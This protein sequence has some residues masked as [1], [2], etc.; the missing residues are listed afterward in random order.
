MPIVTDFGPDVQVYVTQFAIQIFP[1]PAVCPHCQACDTLIGHGFY[2][3]HAT[4]GEHACR[5]WIKRWYCT[6]CQHTTSLLPS[7][8]LRFRHYLLS[9]I[10]AVVVA[11][12]AAHASLSQVCASAATATG[13]PAVITSRDHTC[14]RWCQS[15]KQQAARWWAALQ[16]TLAQHDPHSPGLDP[17][18]EAAGPR[19][20]PAALLHASINLLAWAQ[21]RWAA[22]RSY[23]LSE[24]LRFLWHWGHGQGLGR[25]V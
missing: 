19:D 15:F 9:V 16:Q 12:F 20:A 11:R 2:A 5:L 23:G 14:V 7:F 18:G 8:L 24:R 10:Q 17:L 25:L 22:V 21:T 1:R 4:D 3:R 6:A 13:L